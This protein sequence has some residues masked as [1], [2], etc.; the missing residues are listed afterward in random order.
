[1]TA[2][3][4]PLPL[5]S[6]LA[7]SVLCPIPSARVFF[8]CRFLVCILLP[9]FPTA[10]PAP[11]PQI[12]SPEIGPNT[13]PH[14]KKRRVRRVSSDGAVSPSFARKF[15]RTVRLHRKKTGQSPR[16]TGLRP[17][18]TS[19][20]ISCRRCGTD[21]AY[22]L[23]TPRAGLAPRSSLAPAPWRFAPS[24]ACNLSG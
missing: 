5:L 2:C 1:M 14:Y 12:L 18:L 20:P 15:C 16:F 7:A 21:P 9:S 4:S 3:A 10:N 13:Y 11:S 6:T 22:W 23:R 8:E 17:V 19:R 24:S